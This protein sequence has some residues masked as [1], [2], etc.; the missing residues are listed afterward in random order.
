MK[1]AALSA[2]VVLLG[3]VPRL[4]AKA[5]KC[6]NTDFCKQRPPCEFFYELKVAKAKVRAH[7]KG[8]FPGPLNDLDQ[9]LRAGRFADN[10][11]QK[12]LKKYAKCPPSYFYRSP[13][14]D[15]QVGSCEVEYPG[16]KQSLDEVLAIS[17]SCSEVVEAEFVSSRLRKSLCGSRTP[18]T[19]TVDE[20][21]FNYG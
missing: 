11:F 16:G 18:A 5:V 6:L 9:A 8:S 4:D 1:R 7:S 14:F 2:I 19:T 15:L 20:L 3:L 10:E 12:A 13:A 17:N 21:R